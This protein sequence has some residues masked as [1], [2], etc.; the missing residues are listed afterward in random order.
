MRSD[1]VSWLG[2]QRPLL[3]AL[4]N[5][6]IDRPAVTPPPTTT[7]YHQQPWEALETHLS[8]LSI[9]PYTHRDQPQPLRRTRHRAAQRSAL[10][11]LSAAPF[12]AVMDGTLSPT[13]PP[14][15]MDFPVQLAPWLEVFFFLFRMLL[16]DAR[17]QV[18]RAGRA[19][20]VS[21]PSQRGAGLK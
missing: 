11:F 18:R 3:S 5:S 21:G 9:Y 15:P 16:N 4:M 10:H 14:S 2:Q 17:R 19:F 7:V 6:F 13:T 12:V 8:G 1:A 20:Q